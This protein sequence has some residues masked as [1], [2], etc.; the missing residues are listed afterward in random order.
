MME[1]QAPTTK[2]IPWIWGNIAVK[3]E[4]ILEVGVASVANV[5]NTAAY[6]VE[7]IA[8]VSSVMEPTAPSKAPDWLGGARLA[9]NACSAGTAT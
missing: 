1:K 4:A 6:I 8:P 5:A 7:P 9:N 2:C 3:A